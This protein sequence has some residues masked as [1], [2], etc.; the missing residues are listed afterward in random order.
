MTAYV[1][2]TGIRFNHVEFGG[3]ASSG[4]DTVNP[5]LP[6]TTATVNATKCVV[7]NPRSTNDHLL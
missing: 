6:L 5:A 2:D 1:I 4:I 7:T 3:R